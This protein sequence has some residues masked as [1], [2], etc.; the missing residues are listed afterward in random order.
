MAFPEDYVAVAPGQPVLSAEMNELRKTIAGLPTKNVLGHYGVNPSGTATSITAALQAALDDHATWGRLQ[1]PVPLT[2]NATLIEPIMYGKI[3]EGSSRDRTV[4]EQ[5]TNGA[6]I[7]RTANE[8]AHS[9]VWRDMHLIYQSQQTT[10]GTAFALFGDASPLGF[11]SYWRRWQNLRISNAYQGIATTAGTA[12]PWGSVFDDVLMVSI[13]HRGIAIVPSA[14]G[15]PSVELNNVQIHNNGAALV[16]TGPAIELQAVEALIQNLDV[17]GWHNNAIYLHAGTNAIINNP[18][19]ENHRMTG[20]FPF[21]WQIA[22]AP[23]QIN[24]GT[25]SVLDSNVTGFA[26]LFKIFGGARLLTRGHGYVALAITAGTATYLSATSPA[27]ARLIDNYVAAAGATIAYPAFDWDT[28][29]IARI[30][31]YDGWRAPEGVGTFANGDTT[32][33]VRVIGSVVQKTDRFVCANSGA[34]SITTFDD[35]VNGQEITIRLD[36]NTT[37]V[38]GATLKLAGGAN[39]V[40][41]AND[42]VTLVLISGVWYETGRSVNG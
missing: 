42:M 38:H 29:T 31:H 33:S 13:K 32:P 21:V 34:T 12:M 22:D 11:G 36:A 9:I 27:W 1:I 19:I 16:S 4:I 26:I 40:G 17:E 10:A 24:G 30:A 15:T 20:D 37:L 18:H 39:L 8:E 6:D 23:V 28:A 41:T 35:G 2:I 7:I 14:G 3:V 5:A 25:T